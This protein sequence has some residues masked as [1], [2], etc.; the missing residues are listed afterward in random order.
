[1]P[2]QHAEIAES[3]VMEDGVKETC[4]E[5]K[6]KLISEKFIAALRAYA[7]LAGRPRG[8]RIEEIVEERF[9][10]SGVFDNPVEAGRPVLVRLVKIVTT[11]GRRTW[12]IRCYCHGECFRYA[13]ALNK[14]NFD[15]FCGSK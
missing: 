10:E 8:V 11:A 15:T 4:G 3:D 7:K 12:E 13:P 2:K 1:M 9:V 14:P 5:N 6:P